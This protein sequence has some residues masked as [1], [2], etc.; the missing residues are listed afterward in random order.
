MLPNRRLKQA[1]ELR[2]WSQAKVAREIG[3]DATTVSRWERGLFFPIPYFR[4]RLCTLFCKNAEELGL[5]ENVE[6]AQR[7][8]RGDSSSQSPATESPLQVHSEWQKE[9]LNSENTIILLPPSWSEETDIFSYILQSAAQDQQAHM[10]WKDAYVRA[11]QG[12]SEEAR[13]LGEASLRAFECIG[14]VNALAVREWLNQ[15]FVSS[16]PVPPAPLSI[17]PEEHKPSPT[18]F[19]MQKST[20][21]VVILMGS[22]WLLLSLDIPSAR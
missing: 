2:G 18:Q 19:I 22:L 16:P 5:L 10:L 15:A 3:T 13:Q 21:I 7:R 8:G 1:R 9:D 17:S 6:Q 4:E 14:H 12:H 20:R 11:L